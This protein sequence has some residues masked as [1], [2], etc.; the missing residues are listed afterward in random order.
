MGLL[1]IRKVL[2]HINELGQF[3]LDKVFL[4]KYSGFRRLEKEGYIN[5]VNQD[6]KFY[7]RL[8]KTGLQLLQD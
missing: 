7:A 8:T 5:I 3:P 6:D 4:H 1:L 2:C